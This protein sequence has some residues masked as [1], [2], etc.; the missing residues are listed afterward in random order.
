M[1]TLVP[2]GGPTPAAEEVSDKVQLGAGFPCGGSL[3]AFRA[4]PLYQTFHAGSLSP[5]AA[6]GD[7]SPFGSPDCSSG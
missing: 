7:V 5:D 3:C 4:K 6:V 2:R 1:L